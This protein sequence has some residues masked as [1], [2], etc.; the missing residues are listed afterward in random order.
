MWEEVGTVL[1]SGWE[2]GALRVRC[3][4]A[5]VCTSATF[6]V[7]RR[8]RCRGVGA[9]VGRVDHL[10]EETVLLQCGEKKRWDLCTAKPACKNKRK[11]Y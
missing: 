10:E 7:L 8:G 6:V 4:P 11:L 1:A 5:G 9:V 2:G 3:R